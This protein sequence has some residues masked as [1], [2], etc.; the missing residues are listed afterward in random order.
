MNKF[1]LSDEVY[2]E[3]YGSYVSLLN[4]DQLM[5]L[6]KDGRDE[7][8]SFIEN[9]P[10]DLFFSSYSKGKW[11]IAEVLVHVIDA[12]RV[13]Q[14]RAL[15]FLRNDKTSLPG[16]DQDDF[17]LHC[18]ANSRS[19]KSIIEEYR[20]VRA[21]TISL[22]SGLDDDMLRREGTASNIKWS[23]AVLGFV[24]CGHQKHHQLIL[25]QKY[26]PA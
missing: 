2:N 12:E 19:K 20:T 26:M 23:V 8:I 17:V 21:A 25:E 5:D 16:F 6:F 9:I 7:F 4:D 22:F 18:N 15:R 24:I 13:F 10:G 1:N 11:T 3:F 14:Y